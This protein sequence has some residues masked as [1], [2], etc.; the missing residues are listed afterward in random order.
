MNLNRIDLK[1][2]SL[3]L[4]RSVQPKAV[5]VA[6]LYLVISFVLSELSAR[7][8]G[9]NM[10]MSKLQ[11]YMNHIQSGNLD[12][13]IL[14]LDTMRPSAMG[15]II[16]FVLDIALTVVFAGFNIYLLNAIRNT[17][18]AY[19]NI[20]DGFGIMGKVILL[21][22]LKTIFVA[23]WSMLLVIP[24]IIAAYRYKM[25]LY[26]LIDHPEMSVM[27]CLRE[28]KRMMKGRKMDFFLLELSFIG[29][30]FL[31]IFTLGIG[32]VFLTPYITAAR[33]AF[34]RDIMD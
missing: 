15:Q 24:G 31:S 1:R 8:L 6:L 3:D 21:S 16:S 4:M 27:D 34:Y 17:E 29:W 11:Q 23:L 28:S 33:A 32:N 2:Q 22:L 12:N 7:I 5:Y 26:I 13:A 14:L 30:I 19:G 9:V 20:L 18:P 10:T 25:A